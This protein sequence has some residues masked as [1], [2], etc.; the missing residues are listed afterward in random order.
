MAAERTAQAGW[1][2]GWEAAELTVGFPSSLVSSA[3]PGC[4]VTAGDPTKW[5]EANKEI[6]TH[7]KVMFRYVPALTE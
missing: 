4:C 6:P 5:P 7:G 2:L 3:W 1:E